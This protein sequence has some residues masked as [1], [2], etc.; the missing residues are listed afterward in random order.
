MIHWPSASVQYVKK[1]N[2]LRY[3]IISHWYKDDQH[4]N[5]CMYDIFEDK[6]IYYILNQTQQ[7]EPAGVSSKSTGYLVLNYLSSIK[8][9]IYY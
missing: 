6:Y 9:I 5:K 2:I 4:M 1:K 8:Q 7:C 3:I